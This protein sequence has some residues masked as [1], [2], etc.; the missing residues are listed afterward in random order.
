MIEERLCLPN[1]WLCRSFLLKVIDTV[2]HSALRICSSAFYNFPIVSLYVGC[3]ESPLT[4]FHDKLSLE[5]YYCIFSH[6]YHPLRKH[7]FTREHDTL[8]ENCLGRIPNF[9]IKI[10][11]ILL[12]SPLLDIRICTCFLLNPT[13]WN[14]KGF[15]C[16]NFFE[17]FDKCNTTA[18]VYHAIFASDRSDFPEYIDVYTV[19]IFGVRVVESQ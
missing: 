17:N 5:M 12:G 15:S 6:S 9:D 10:L 14:I 18:N 7:L 8:Y 4:L 11:N 2:H 3:G 1:L 19:T 13:P 16:I